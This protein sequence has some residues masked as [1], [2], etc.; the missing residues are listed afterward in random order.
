MTKATKAETVV[1]NWQNDGAQVT[2]EPAADTGFDI[3]SVTLVKGKTE[4]GKARVQ[5]S[6]ATHSGVSS[7]WKA[8]VK[9]L[10]KA[11][12]L[13]PAAYPLDGI[14]PEWPSV[15]EPED[16]GPSDWS[17]YPEHDALK[18]SMEPARVA[19]GQIDAG[20][21]EV[22]TGIRA[23]ASAIDS[24]RQI[25]RDDAKSKVDGLTHFDKWLM[26]V[27]PDVFALCAKSASVKS[28]WGM[29]AN[30][31]ATMFEA[32]PKT[33]VSAKAI[34]LRYNSVKNAYAGKA[35]ERAFGAAGGVPS[36]ALAS[37]TLI[38]VLDS[39]M[40]EDGDRP[41]GNGF[42]DQEALEFAIAHHSSIFNATEAGSILTVV[43]DADAADGEGRFAVAKDAKG[44]PVVGG[45]ASVGRAK[46]PNEMVAA[47]VKALN[48]EMGA[49]D[50]A[51]EEA[52][53][54]ADQE[55]ADAVKPRTFADYTPREAAAHLANILSAHGEWGDVLGELNAM[56]DLVDGGETWPTVIT[57]T[58]AETSA[59]KVEAE[60]EEDAMDEA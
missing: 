49:A 31:P 45:L 2:L 28:E 44:N 26:D 34:Q 18:A 5:A 36:E 11:M 27:S 8:A 60:A 55:A 59:A 33:A 4:D 12:L 38:G 56:A 35:A 46:S 37:Q 24:A 43:W 15:E 25:L 9:A 47:Y 52:E 41:T 13:D 30:I 58:L 42:S 32:M 3:L 16:E 6:T 51:R 7:N 57:Q 54:K 14:E 50:K 21:T 22:K 19:Y 23:L 20:E 40:S 17:E 39:A 29:V 48:A 1:I 10:V 53:A